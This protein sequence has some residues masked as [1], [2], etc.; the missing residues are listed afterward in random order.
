[1]RLVG[2]RPP[3]DTKLEARFGRSARALDAALRADAVTTRRRSTSPE[4]VGGFVRGYVAGSSLTVLSARFAWSTEMTR[5]RLLK[6]GV[7]I[8]DTQG[9]GI[10]AAAGGPQVLQA[11]HYAAVR[12]ARRPHWSDLVR[13]R[14]PRLLL[15]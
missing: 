15:W 2:A 4:V 10:L 13:A 11:G 12:M 14:W 8:R 3:G 7:I 1:M 6:A 5:A 9:R